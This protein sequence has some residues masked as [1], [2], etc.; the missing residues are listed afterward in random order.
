M[1]WFRV[2]DGFHNHPKVLTAGTAAAGLYCRCGSYAAQQLTDGFIP[3]AIAAAYGTP[4]WAQRLVAAG[5][6]AVVDG[7]FQMPD[8]LEY[9]RSKEQIMEERHAKA[10]R[11]KRWRETQKRRASSASTNASVDGAPTRPTPLPKGE[12]GGGRTSRRNLTPVDNWCGHCDPETRQIEIDSTTLA[13]C[14]ACHP[15]RSVG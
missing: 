13:R 8:F 3:A 5:L 4:E 9:N 1:V 15:H 14:P 6:W 2:D 10:E 11:Q 12:R 7:G